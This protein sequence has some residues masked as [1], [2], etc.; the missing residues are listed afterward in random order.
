MANQ[1]IAPATTGTTLYAQDTASLRQLWHKGALIGEEEED[2][3]QQFE[4]ASER[5]P[6]WTI[7]DTSKGQGQKMTFT[8]TSGYYGEGKYGEGLFEGP[9]DYETDD[10]SSYNLTVDFVRNAASRSVRADELMGLRDELGSMVPIKLGKWLGRTK[11]DQIMGLSVLTLPNENRIYAGGRTFDTLGS[12]D[13]LSWDDVIT[14]GAA[15]KPLGGMPFRMGKSG[16]NAISS[17]LFI[18]S[19]TA[20]LSLRLDSSYQTLLSNADNRGAGNVLFKGGYPNIDGHTIAPHNALNHAGK[21]PV[22]SFLAPE[23]FLGVAITGNADA[24]RTITGGGSDNADNSLTGAGKPLW[25]KYFGGHDYRF[26]DTGVLDV[27]AATVG[28]VAG[29]YY[30]IIY[31]TTGTNAG[32]WGFVKYTTGNDGNKIVITEFLTGQ[33]GGTYRKGTVGSVTW[34]GTINTEVWDS[35]ALIIPANA[36]GVPIGHTMVLGAGGIV[37]GYGMWRAKRTQE[38]DNGDFLKRTYITSVFGQSLRK[39]RKDRVPAVMLLTT[40]LSRPGITLPTVS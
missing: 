36:K 12:A 19:E 18:P 15:M 4:G 22:G 23:A 7:N 20:A 30:A 39:D 24:A 38:T 10:I 13:V 27:S 2:F 31:N 21:G 34:S 11:K 32:K 14:A 16:L 3:L 8:T 33:A 40:A 26:V 25:F 17:Q 35:G 6:V 9:S 1:D 37:R 5:S 28:N 29:P